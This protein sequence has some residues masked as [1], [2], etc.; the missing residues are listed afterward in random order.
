MDTLLILDFGSQTTQLIARRIRDLGVYARI[1]P[2]DSSLDGQIDEDTRGLVLSGSPYSVYEPDSP[3]PDP[4]LL[5]L[6]LPV[7]GICY[8]VQRLIHD[9]G[10]TV[11]ALPKREFGRAA[12]HTLAPSP[13]LDGLPDGFISW[14]SHGDTVRSLAPGYRI[15]ATT[16]NELPAVIVHEDQP[17]YGLQFHP[18]VTHSEH[19]ERLLENFALRICGA[20]KQWNVETYLQNIR[21][22]TL[23]TVGDKR[24]LLLTSGGVDSTVVAALLLAT[25]PAD[26]VHLMYIDSGL[27]RK[28]ESEEVAEL[29]GRLGARHLHVIDASDRFLDVL[30]GISD[31]EEK[32]RVIGDMFIHVQEQEINR[33]SIQNSYLAQGTL[34]TDMI[35]SGKGVGKKADVIKSHHNVRSPLVEEKRK[36]GLLL[37]PLAELYKDEVRR[38]GERLGLARDTVWR[39]PFPGPGLA[40]RILGEVTR[41][42]V[43][44]L[45]NADA[46]YIEE[47]KKRD[48]YDQIW[49]AFSV[50]LPLRSVGVAGDI[51]R[52]GFVLALRAVVSRDGMTADVYPFPTLD[53]VEISSRITNE[54]PE[55][56]RVVYDVS[57]KPPAT[58]E[59]E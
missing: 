50:M 46:I 3:R 36:R 23:R 55:I 31:P 25:L 17:I 43:R 48:L 39:H 12:V 10:G 19:G 45:Q 6:G 35:E 24:V 51:R 58:I 21:E 18:E 52:Y 29:L 54:I 22:E 38:L 11:A 8:G 57:S 20:R 56:G 2:G 59:W 7:L 1:I 16:E 9:Q 32:R 42:K 27:M 44:I 37:E 33:L 26:Q 30:K 13:L 5:S 49:Q 28:N 14:M 4:A 41:E 47:L 15:V 40:V 34:Y 53:L